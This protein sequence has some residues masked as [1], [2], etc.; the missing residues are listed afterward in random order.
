MKPFNRM[1][2]VFLLC[3]SGAASFFVGCIAENPNGGPEDFGGVPAMTCSPAE[4]KK[5]CPGMQVSIDPCMRGE[6]DCIDAVASVCENGPRLYCR[7]FEECR[8]IA[9]DFSCESGTESCDPDTDDACTI[10]FEGDGRCTP[11]VYCKPTQQCEAEPGCPAGSSLS[12]RPCEPGEQACD[13][14]SLCGQTIFCREDV[15]DQ[16]PPQCDPWETSE[17]R[18]PCADWEEDSC[19]ALN[20]CSSTIYC[21][22]PEDCPTGPESL[23]GCPQGFVMCH[24]DNPDANPEN[25]ELH[26]ERAWCSPALYCAPA[27][28]EAEP[29]CPEGFEDIEERCAPGDPQCLVVR[30]CETTLFCR[31]SARCRATPSCQPGEFEAHDPCQPG[32]ECTARWACGV[33][34]Y[35]RP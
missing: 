4:L 29:E 35:C 1:R 30:E 15:C 20:F 18:E 2:S 33:V 8:P 11:T 22:Q 31:P 17:I 27:E 5:A 26:Q 14:V 10:Q 24:P 34:V 32:E 3:M 13:E 12:E 6:T 16:E 9:Q 25:C 19:R 23:I 21:R 28:C 7:P